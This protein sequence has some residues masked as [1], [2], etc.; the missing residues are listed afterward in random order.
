ML[1]KSV[2]LFEVRLELCRLLRD[3]VGSPVVVGDCGQRGRL[4][5]Q[6]ADV[7]LQYRD[8]VVEFGSGEI[9]LHAFP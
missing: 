5:D 6:L 7:V 9:V 1:P 3:P 2:A 8:S 4:F